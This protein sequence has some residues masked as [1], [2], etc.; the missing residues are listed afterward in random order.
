KGR[1]AGRPASQASRANAVSRRLDHG[2]D[3]DRVSPQRPGCCLLRL[4]G[5]RGL[6]GGGEGPLLSLPR[7]RGAVFPGGRHRK[8]SGTLTEELLAP[9]PA[10][11]RSFARDTM[12]RRCPMK[13]FIP[14]A[15]AEGP[16]TQVEAGIRQF[17]AKEPGAKLDDRRVRSLSYEQRKNRY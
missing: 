13:P 1:A 17:L 8:A 3:R 11:I 12:N 5:R 6:L 15:E 9:A 7:T 16:A 10:A 4:R 2:E 14:L